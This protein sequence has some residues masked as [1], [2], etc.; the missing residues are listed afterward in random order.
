MAFFLT[1]F[2]VLVFAISGFWWLSGYDSRLTGEYEKADRTRR[3]IRCGIT[4][5]L[6]EPAFWC[7]WQYAQH[8]D[9][10]AGMAYIM[11]TLPLAFIWVGCLS[12]MFAHG[13]HWLIDPEDKREFD[14]HKQ[15]RDLDTLAA[16]V[17]NGRKEEA[18]KLCR[19]LKESGD[20]SATAMDVMLERLGVS[21]NQIQKPKPLME[22]SRLREQGR[23]A[24]AELILNSLLQEN[25]GNV[26]AALMLMRFYAQDLKRGD[27]AHEVLKSLKQQPYVSASH[28]EFAS[29]SIHE[30]R[31]PRPQETVAETLP[32]SVEELLA[33][34]YFGTAIEVLEQK[35]ESQPEDFDLRVKLIEIYAVHFNDFPSVEKILRQMEAFFTPAQIESARAKLREL[36]NAGLQ[37][38]Y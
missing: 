19:A 35:I 26:D 36:R 29:R 16:L 14:A 17:R 8:D 38:N 3:M 37:Q 9:R 1:N 4:L 18:I 20:A 34:G 12:E 6:I 10:A 23:F 2:V 33:Q 15:I 27:K 22:A 5:L 7:L 31:N 28:I 32:E 24:E 30:W 25:P 21:Q 11:F 13:F